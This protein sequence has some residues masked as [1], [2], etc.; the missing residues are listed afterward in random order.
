MYEDVWE[1]VTK[2]DREDE[3]MTTVPKKDVSQTSFFD[4]RASILVMDIAL[5][6]VCK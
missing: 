6:N 5:R 4:V 3:I 1:G 2:R